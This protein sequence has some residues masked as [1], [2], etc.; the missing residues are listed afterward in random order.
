M[1][2]EIFQRLVRCFRRVFPKVSEADIPSLAQENTAAWD[3]VAHVTLLSLLGE[4]FGVDT[5]F[6]GFDSALTFPA[7]LEVVRARTVNARG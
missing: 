1:Q 4:E 6:E 7:M 5:D 2:D 3:S